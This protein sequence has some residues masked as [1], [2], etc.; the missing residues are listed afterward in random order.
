MPE[1]E[2]ETTYVNNIFGLVTDKRVVY[3]PHRGWLIGGLEEDRPLS[4]V[5]SVRVETS[6]NLIG[7]ILLVLVGVPAII[8]LVG[9][10]FIL[11]GVCLLWGSPTVVVNTTDGNREVMKGWPWHRGLADDF[12][13]ALQGQIVKG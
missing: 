4:H 8:A 6:R 7:G 12:V 9:V 3:H 1:A 11:F 13:K 2:A 10:I 5:A